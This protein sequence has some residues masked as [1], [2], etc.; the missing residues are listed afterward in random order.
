MK[1]CMGVNSYTMMRERNKSTEN[2]HEVQSLFLPTLTFNTNSIH[3]CTNH[4][5]WPVDQL[6][7]ATRVLHPPVT[8]LVYSDAFAM[9]L[10]G[11]VYGCLCITMDMDILIAMPDN[12]LEVVIETGKFFSIF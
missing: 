6:S 7:I 3:C 4:I 11:E 5:K 1:G 2:L 12:H 9:L 10:N 8:Q